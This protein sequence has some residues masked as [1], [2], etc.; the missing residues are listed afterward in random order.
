MARLT[1][2]QEAEVES[3]FLRHVDEDEGMSII[4]DLMTAGYVIREYEAD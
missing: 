1:R 2:E 4:Q 3:I